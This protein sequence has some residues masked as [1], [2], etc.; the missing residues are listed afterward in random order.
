MGG[1]RPAAACVSRPFGM[2]PPSL[3]AACKDLL[4]EHRWCLVCV[5]A[6]GVS[7]SLRVSGRSP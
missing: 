2:P 1:G 6:N 7:M 4:A 3:P 5:L